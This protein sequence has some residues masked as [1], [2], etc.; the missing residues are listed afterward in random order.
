MLKANRTIRDSFQRRVGSLLFNLECRALFDLPTMDVNGT[1]KVFPRAFAKLLELA[2]DDD[3]IDV[4]FML[5]LPARG[6]SA[7]RGADPRDR[8]ARRPSR[9]RATGRRSGCTGAWRMKREQRIGGARPHDAEWRDPRAGRRA[10][11]GRRAGRACAPACAARFWEALDGRLRCS[12][13]AS[14]STSS[15]R[16]R[17]DGR[18]THMALP[19]PSGLAVDAT[20]RVT[21]ASTRNPNQLVELAPGRRAEGAAARPGAHR[22]PPGALYL[23][24][25]AYV[26]GVLHGNAVG[27]NAVV[28]LDRE[29][30]ERVWWPK[31]IETRRGPGLLAQLPPAQL[32]RGRRDLASSFFSAS[33]D[34]DVRAAARATA[35]SRS[36]AAA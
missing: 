31:A 36:T 9:R 17:P 28:R 15:S 10:L 33:A 7:A 20:E 34:A 14:T 11:G 2:R 3:L 27:Q 24:D 25:L 18:Q 26:G 4:E 6:L 23:H 35:T 5:D 16:S 29:R 21:V 8:A 22:V 32:D 13:R 12:S 19:H 30:A 1:P